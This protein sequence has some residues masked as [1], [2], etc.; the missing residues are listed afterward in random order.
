MFPK[1]MGVGNVIYQYAVNIKE[2]AQFNQLANLAG[3]VSDER[4]ERIARYRFESDKIRCVI[5]ELLVRYLLWT[6]YGM[7][8]QTLTICHSEYGKPYFENSKIHFNLSH[9][10]DWVV[11]AMG[12]SEMGVDVEAIRPMDFPSVYR[13]FSKNEIAQLNKED[14]EQYPDLFYQIWTLKE[15]YVKYLGLGLQYPFSSFSI[16]PRFNDKTFVIHTDIA[17]RV[18]FF[19]S[20][21][22][23]N[24][25][26]A[27]CMDALEPFQS[28]QRLPTEMLCNH[29]Y[30]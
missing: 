24:H 17:E 2:I 22:D 20:K 8:A 3:A 10:G 27:L 18:S 29:F 12:D 7:D 25:W 4:K 1:E 19:S 6:Q 26:Y 13:A 14:I 9:S 11:C 5:A 28:V 16:I 15:S 23:E 30:S 21:L